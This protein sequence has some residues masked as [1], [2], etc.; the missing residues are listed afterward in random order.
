MMYSKIIG[1][2]GYLPS[3]I[4]SN[5]ELS[6]SMQTSDE[7]IYSRTGIRQRHLASPDESC[8]DMAFY[9][10]KRALENAHIEADAIDLIIVATSTPEHIF[11]STATVV[12]SRLSCQRAAAFDVQAACTGFM[13]ALNT[14][15]CFIKSG[16]YQ[17]VLVIGAEVFSRI[18][19]WQDRNTA[20]LFGDGAG[21]VVLS[22]SEE[23]GILGTILHADGSH[24]ELLW[25][26]QGIGSSE[27]DFAT[28]RPFI[29]MQGREVFKF[30]VRSL[31]HLVSEL[32]VQCQMSADEIDF[33]IPHQANSR[34]I[35]AV[36]EHLNLPI[37]K[38]IITVNQHANTSAASVPLALDYGVQNGIIKRGDNLLLEAFGGGFTW[39]GCILTY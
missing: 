13:Y 12:Q 10:A 18:V 17:N 11:P 7:W 37:E 28:R 19:D 29:K 21:A 36:A 9:A 4:V 2:G 27:T 1:T 3:R 6:Q 16:Q 39:G 20:V 30:A 26:P 35:Q 33:L 5:D 38:V 15:D 8:S 22:A 14:A 31:T 25:V 23:A 34:I 32:L 24:K